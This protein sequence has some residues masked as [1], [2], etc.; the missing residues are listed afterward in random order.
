MRIEEA[1]TGLL[2]GRCWAKVR[3]EQLDGVARL[4]WYRRLGFVWT[5]EV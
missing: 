3:A 5:V 1:Y 4:R 2:R